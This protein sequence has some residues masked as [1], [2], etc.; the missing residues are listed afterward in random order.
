M[1]WDRIVSWCDA[2]SVSIWEF[3]LDIEKKF[4]SL[5]VRLVTKGCDEVHL[6]VSRETS[7][8]LPQ[9]P[10]LSL[11]LSVCLCLSVCLSMSHC[12]CGPCRSVSRSHLKS[13]LLLLM[14]S[15]QVFFNYICF[16]VSNKGR[17]AFSISLHARSAPSRIFCPLF[18]FITLFPSQNAIPY[19]R[20]VVRERWRWRALK[21]RL[22][23][24]TEAV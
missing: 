7:D 12:T 6:S 10:H 5:A 1:R 4:S 9:I 18:V 8:L 11:S 13:P 23:N 15:W 17:V 19:R 22:L 14:E 3:T 20:A 2:E 21:M 24:D 16:S